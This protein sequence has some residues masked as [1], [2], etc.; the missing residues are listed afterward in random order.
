MPINVPD[1]LPANEILRAEKIF[2]MNESLAVRQDIRAL[3]IGILNLMP[4]KLATEVQLLRLLSNSPL[5][6]DITLLRMESHV[7]KNT[8]ADYLEA[9][10]KVF[11]EIRKKKYDGFI[12][13]GAPV[14]KLDYEQVTYWPELCDILEWTKTN[15]TSVFHICWGAQAALYYHYSVKK[16]PL[17]KKAFGVFRH[18]KLGDP[19]LLRGFDEIFCVPHSRHTEILSAD[20]AEIS[21][22]EI[23]SESDESG[24]YIAATKDG[25]QIFV[26]GHS[27]YDANSLLDEYRRDL[28]QGLEIAPP[29]N[30]FKEGTE[31]P[32][33]TWRAHSNLLF[34]NWLNYFVYQETPYE[35]E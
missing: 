5:Q 32:V 4:N 15:V 17:D 3:K 6:I 8:S 18:K 19:I 34:M 2:V 12:I 16:Q 21:E 13:T 25:K 26:T 11:P 22:L 27:E 1:K 23:L 20:V 29:A 31:E 24:L 10:Y 7:S 30:Y 9:Y 35:I 33:V 28:S 14:E